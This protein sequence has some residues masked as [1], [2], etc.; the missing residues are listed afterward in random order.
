ML[1][2]TICRSCK[3]PNLT[4]LNAEMNIH[5]LGLKSLNQ[6]SILAFPR[7]VVCL[8]CGLTESNLPNEE[9]RQLRECASKVVRISL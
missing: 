6:P 7:L 2:S 5:L 8:D 9:L 4:E 3:S 1:I